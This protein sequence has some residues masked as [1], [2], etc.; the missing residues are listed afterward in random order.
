[1]QLHQPVSYEI[2]QVAL[3]K[4]RRE[5]KTRFHLNIGAEKGLETWNYWERGGVVQV[6]VIRSENGGEDARQTLLFPG[7]L[8]VR[9][10]PTDVFDARTFVEDLNCD[11]GLL[12]AMLSAPHAVL[13]ARV[14]KGKPRCVSKPTSQF[15]SS[16]N[17]R[18]SKTSVGAVRTLRRP[19]KSRV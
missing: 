10:A 17:V 18:A 12:F 11:V 13:K 19:G 2:V 14:L 7:R 8:N 1:M 9:T 15:R 4:L 16:T 6:D 5:R 3:K